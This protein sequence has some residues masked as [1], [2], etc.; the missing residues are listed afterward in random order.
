MIGYWRLRNF[1]KWGRS[2][3]FPH[4]FL[5]PVLFNCFGL[6]RGWY[7]CKLTRS[8]TGVALLLFPFPLFLAGSSRLA[9]C[10]SFP[11][12][13]SRF[14]N[15]SDLSKYQ[16]VA[17]NLGSN[18]KWASRL[19][20]PPESDALFF[21]RSRVGRTLFRFPWSI[22]HVFSRLF[23]SERKCSLFLIDVCDWWLLLLYCTIVE[24]DRF[25]AIGN[26]NLAQLRS[27][28]IIPFSFLSAR[29]K[30]MAG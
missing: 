26:N 29:F 18:N 14:E 21:A 6:W 7:V 20:K 13:F 12:K 17:F 28:H 19:T 22:N 10:Q 15:Q 4:F 11:R 16:R 27:L 3:F 9:D 1:P 24:S 5:F 25:I 23:L 8:A 30:I 2:F